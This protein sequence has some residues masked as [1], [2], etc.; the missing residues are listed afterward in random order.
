MKLYV[1]GPMRGKP[2]RNA[3]AFE[4]ATATLRSEGHEV[5]S[6][7]EMDDEYGELGDG[8][9]GVWDTVDRRA[10]RRDIEALFGCH[11]V[12]VLP[13]WEASEGAT[14]EVTVALAAGIPVLPYGQEQVGDWNV[15]E[16]LEI[17]QAFAQLLRSG[18]ADGANKRRAGAKPSWKIDPEHPL[19]LQNHLTR[20]YEGDLVDRDSGAHPLVH[21][22]W[23][24]LAIAWQDTTGAEADSSTGTV[25]Q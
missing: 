7:A 1:A 16:P 13:G 17:A 5:I 11:A 12:V 22:A 14:L 2:A 6:P 19:K 15:T 10:I 9:A 18:T 23:R 21:A 4:E 24:C 20:Y 25:A 3:A 8:V